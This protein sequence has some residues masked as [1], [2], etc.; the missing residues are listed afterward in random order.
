MVDGSDAVLA[1]AWS[2]I[3]D[4]FAAGASVVLDAVRFLLVAA[5]CA[6]ECAVRIYE[7][8]RE[9]GYEKILHTYYK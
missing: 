8:Y 3:L 2:I 4:I 1:L 7:R 9:R 5:G 6:V